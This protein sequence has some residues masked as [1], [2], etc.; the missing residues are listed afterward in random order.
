MID[1]GGN[2]VERRFRGEAHRWDQIY[3]DSGHPLA[4][5][6]DRLTRDNVRRRFMRTF[7]AAGDLAGRSVLDLGCGS[8]RYLIEAV[9]RG[10]KRAVG[11]DFAPEMI[12]V[13]R[14]LAGA[15]PNG[16]RIQLCC[17]DVR[18]RE[19]TGPFDLVIANG[20]FDYVESP[21]PVLAAAWH[22]TS[23]T[24]VA[25]FPNAFAPRA[26]PRWMYWRMRGLTIRLFQREAIVA[27]ARAASI[28]SPAIER[29]G[30]IFML[31]ARR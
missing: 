1:T 22:R 30:P 23:G 20:L 14:R 4:R 18:D 13:A 11:V 10:A 29:I 31:I 15:S 2:G 5:L 19:P 7:E 8:G 24:L 16:D 26:L 21:L 12:E 17:G 9:S 25:T 3:D 28:E 6:W 27:A